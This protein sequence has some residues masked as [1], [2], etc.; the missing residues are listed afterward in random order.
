MNESFIYKETSNIWY[1]LNTYGV[2]LLYF[3]VLSYLWFIRKAKEEFAHIAISTV[4]TVVVV[5]VVK[6]LSAIPRP[7]EVEG[8]VPKAGFSVRTSSLPS[9]HTA[10]SFCLATTVALHQ[11]K[12]GIILFLLSGI[13]GI[14]RVFAFV[15]YPVDV[16]LGSILGTLT[17]LA[18]E[19]LKL[20]KHK[21]L[22]N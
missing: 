17:A 18:C 14:G 3:F 19:N 4:I 21:K 5:L 13:I 2:F 1:F 8:L 15:H 9:L 22:G 10:L 20:P 6:E 11:R 12:F 7:Y 16:I